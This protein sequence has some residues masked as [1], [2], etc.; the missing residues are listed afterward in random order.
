MATTENTVEC[1]TPPY[2]DGLRCSASTDCLPGSVCVDGT[3]GCCP[4]V[5][6]K[7]GICAL[8]R[9]DNPAGLLIRMANARDDGFGRDPYAGD[10]F[11]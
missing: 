7:K 5:D 2:C 10:M 1:G 3:R 9:C 8:A 11:G 6:G 4:P